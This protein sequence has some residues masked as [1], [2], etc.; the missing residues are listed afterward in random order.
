MKGTQQTLSTDGFARY[1]KPTRREH[2]L[3]EMNQVV[4]LSSLTTLRE[5]VY[6]K[7]EGAER[8]PVG[9]GRML[10]IH[11]LQHGFNLSEPVPAIR[12]DADAWG[13]LDGVPGTSGERTRGALCNTNCLVN[14][15]N[16][17]VTFVFAQYFGDD[18]DEADRKLR[19]ALCGLLH[20]REV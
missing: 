8:P 20:W 1:R 3:V 9:L 17:V 16:Q 10:R 6:P 19:D 13:S 18:T 14:R 2:F 4:P 11:R 7:G 5:P 12:A 15:Q